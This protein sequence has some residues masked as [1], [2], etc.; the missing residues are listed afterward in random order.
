MRDGEAF[1]KDEEGMEFFDI[2][3]AQM[4][5]VAS[6]ADMVVDLSRKAPSASG[7]PMSIEVRD[8][9]GPLSAVGLTFARNRSLRCAPALRDR[10][11]SERGSP[12]SVRSSW[13][14]R[15]NRFSRIP[16]RSLGTTWKRQENLAILTRL[17]N[18]FLI[19]IEAMIRLGERRR[20]VLSNKAIIAY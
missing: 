3:N 12:G 11:L 13:T 19:P 16:S 4:E 7:H 20:L 2:V 14:T 15:C 5:A 8:I 10:H 6:L 18:I 1:S 9:Q 17:R